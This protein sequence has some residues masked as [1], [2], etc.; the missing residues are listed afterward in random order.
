MKK[1]PVKSTAVAAS[2]VCSGVVFAAGLITTSSQNIAAEALAAAG[3][4]VVTTASANYRMGIDVASGVTFFVKLSPVTGSTLNAGVA[5]TTLPLLRMTGSTLQA[6]GLVPSASSTISLAAGDATGCSWSIKALP[7]NTLSFP[8][9]ATS[10]AVVPS[11]ATH[12]L[13]TVGGTAGISI[14]ITD[15]NGQQ[16]DNTSALSK[17][18]ATSV[19]SLSMTAAADTATQADVNFVHPTSKAA[20]PLYGFVVAGDD[21]ATVAKANFTIT[22]N[23]VATAPTGGASYNYGG[24]TNSGIAMT[25]TGDF[26]G[27]ATPVLR[28]G[29]TA[30][31]GVTVAVATD[32][33]SA[34]FTI[35]TAS[36]VS[37]ADGLNVFTL[38]LPSTASQTLGTSRTFGIKGTASPQVGAAVVL[39]PNAS[40]W[41][42]SANAIQ[43]MSP[44]FSLDPAATN[45]SRFIFSNSGDP[46]T[47]T[48][49]CT[50]ATGVT[51]T[52]GTAS[53]GSLIKGQTVLKAMD[54]CSVGSGMNASVV[55]TINAPAG[56]IKGVYEKIINGSASAYLPLSRP[57]GATNTGNS[58]VE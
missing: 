13:A 47:Y 37:S 32:N 4:T 3:T 58:S 48:S 28:K 18:V 41:T 52:A 9:S 35:P 21:T 8:A 10:I 56:G 19:Q 2:F 25:V 23:P 43:L 36:I 51:T 7:G 49:A 29:A 42:W 53:G 24:E 11:F 1:F 12:S 5:C 44:T 34:T 14:N 27:L 20:L 38:D 55:F 50:G 30:V 26:T 40:W 33:K 57:Y 15:I 45:I 22:Q 17:T 16:L 31:S 54:V 6:D 39:T 46:A